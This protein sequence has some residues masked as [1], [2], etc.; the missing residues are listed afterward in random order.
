MPNKIIGRTKKVTA[1]D[2]IS[3]STERNL[4]DAFLMVVLYSL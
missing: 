4:A 3:V 1:N 2:M